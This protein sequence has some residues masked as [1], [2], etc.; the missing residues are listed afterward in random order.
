MKSKKINEFLTER[1][2]LNEIVMKY[3]GTHMKKFYSLDTQTY[4]GDILPERKRRA[5]APSQTRV[6]Q[7]MLN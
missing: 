6:R 7:Q 4:Q 3:A 5:W 1:K 2:R